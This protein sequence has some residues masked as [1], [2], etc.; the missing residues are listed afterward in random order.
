MFRF[1]IRDVFS[2]CLGEP[3]AARQAPRPCSFCRK[4][5]KPLVEG[6]GGVLICK[7][8]SEMAVSI[9]QTEMCP[10]KRPATCQTPRLCSFCLR[11]ARPMVEGVRRVFICKQCS[12]VALS[13]LQTECR[14]SRSSL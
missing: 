5:A 3:L 7:T 1:T 13:M 14:L 2:L 12:E 11:D 9:F 8:C 4:D 6:V 10:G